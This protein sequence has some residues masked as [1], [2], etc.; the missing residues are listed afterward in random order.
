MILP[1]TAY[2]SFK[3]NRDHVADWVCTVINHLA[4]PHVPP[5]CIYMTGINVPLYK[6]HNCNKT[7]NIKVPT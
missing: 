1:K 2:L 4:A 7:N 5:F 3:T 6:L